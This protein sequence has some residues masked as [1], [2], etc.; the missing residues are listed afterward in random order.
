MNIQKL[1]DKIEWSRQ[2]LA[3]PCRNR[4]EAVKQFVGRNYADNGS[5]KRVPVNL[6]ELAVTIYVR[7]LAAHAPRCLV[8]TEYP[9]LRPFAADMECVLNQIPEEIGLERTLRDAVLEAL[10]SFAVVKTGISVGDKGDEPF[11]SLVQMD[12]YFVDMSART[13]SEVQYEG[14]E[15]WMDV[16]EVKELYGAELEADDYSGVSTQGEPQA[17]AVTVNE[18]S[19]P[20]YDRV[21]LRDV[22]L[23]RRNRL[24]TY[25]VGT[26]K[27][28]RDV[29]W[30]GPDGTPYIKLGFS[31]VPGNLLPLPPVATWRDLHE[32]ANSLFRKLARQADAKKTVAAFQ[33]G[34]DEEVE[35]LRMANDGDGI[36]YNGAKPDEITVGGI[37]QPTLAFFISVKDINNVMAGNL[38]SLGGLAPQSKTATQ[39]RLISEASSSRVQDMAD[40]TVEFAKAIF[41]R[42]AWYTWTDPVR[43]RRFRKV[44]SRKYDIGVT[45]EWTP[46][47]R[48]GDFVDYN[49]DIDVF[50]M[51]DDSPS[52]RVQTILGILDRLAPYQQQ[53]AEQ[54][55]FIDMKYLTDILGKYSGVPE[56]GEVVKFSDRPEAGPHLPPKG[57]PRP[58]YV[59]TK[60]PVT[61]RV[62][63]RVNRPGATTQ[64]RDAAMMQTLLGGRAQPAEM[65]ALSMSRPTA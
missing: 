7:L 16:D 40:R 29:P 11:V 53:L 54:G 34:N 52:T 36:R 39:E 2:K 45:G 5:D 65:A 18:T 19:E 25:A 49:F 13:W 26:R 12:D 50:S 62:Y 14:N 44:V 37:D 10:F 15:Y 47:T 33:G 4:V 1:H 61:H 9:E 17:H 46:E 6:L 43:R 22:Y 28:L 35:R 38:D 27:V 23:V 8:R 57:D 42:L 56:I 32:L 3:T 31:T 20:F 48:D 63:E 51:R 58:D 41:R 64:G 60:S 30:D 55:A 24:V 21:L 59:S